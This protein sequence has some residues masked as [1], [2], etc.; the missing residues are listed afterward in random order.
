MVTALLDPF[1]VCMIPCTAPDIQMSFPE[2]T[3]DRGT[4]PLKAFVN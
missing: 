3:A 2:I 1:V 4:D